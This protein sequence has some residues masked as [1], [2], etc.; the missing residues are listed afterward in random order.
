MIWSQTSPHLSII[1][2]M[3]SDSCSWINMFKT[4]VST[5]M[6]LVRKFNFKIRLFIFCRERKIII[7]TILWSWINKFWQKNT[8]RTDCL[9]W[10]SLKQFDSE[11]STD[12]SRRNGLARAWM[13][14]N[15]IKK[16]MTNNTSWEDFQKNWKTEFSLI[17]KQNSHEWKRN[18]QI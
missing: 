4:V 3:N 6:F 13:Q 17:E 7:P 16:K 14:T 10:E 5:I 8:D 9:P 11:S 15:Q 2:W 12:S 1:I 18:Q